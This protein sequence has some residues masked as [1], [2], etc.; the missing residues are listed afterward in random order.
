[1]FQFTIADSRSIKAGFMDF[2][3]DQSLYEYEWNFIFVLPQGGRLSAHNQ[4]TRT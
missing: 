2:F 3:S 1:M 4:A